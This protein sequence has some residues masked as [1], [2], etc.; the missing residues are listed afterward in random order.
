MKKIS[1]AIVSVCTMLVLASFSQANNLILES[2]YK[3]CIT[4][5]VAKCERIAAM[6]N[7]KSECIRRCAKINSLKTKFFKNNKDEL[8]HA[9]VT[10]NVG[11]KPY[12]V[13]YFLIKAFFNAH[14][15]LTIHAKR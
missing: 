14:P 8:V 9:M 6:I 4:K 10:Q 5:K 7:S 1:I 13:D 3:D 15:E 12:K 11:M 2:Y